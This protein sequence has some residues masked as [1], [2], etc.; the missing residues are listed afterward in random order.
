MLKDISSSHEGRE[1]RSDSP[2]KDGARSHGKVR[3]FATHPVT[4]RYSKSDFFTLRSGERVLRLRGG[5]DDD[6]NYGDLYNTGWYGDSSNTGE[7]GGSGWQED[8]YRYDPFRSEDL[9]K[10]ENPF[11][12]GRNEQAHTSDSYSEAIKLLDEWKIK[13]SYE[14]SEQA[15]KQLEEWR[16]Q[17]HEDSRKDASELLCSYSSQMHNDSDDSN[18]DA[19]KLFNDFRSRMH[20]DS[21]D[22]AINLFNDLRSKMYDVSGE[23]VTGDGHRGVH[24]GDENDSLDEPFYPD[25]SKLENE[26]ARSKFEKMVNAIRDHFKPLDLEGAWRDLQNDPVPHPGRPDEPFQHIKE[27]EESLQ[28]CRNAI[29]TYKDLKDNPKL[30]SGDRLIMEALVSRASKTIDY[31]EKVVYRDQ[32]IP[33]ERSYI[34][35]VWWPK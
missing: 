33:G 19:I 34:F 28:S 10:Y 24:D 20:G 21:K 3:D 35:E 12:Q 4:Y 25:P 15:I 7:Y 1:P 23:N 5:A 26:K 29:E 2:T 30:S 18:E 17:L 14:S 6:A 16:S 9:D 27:V 11:D 8:P 13:T 32:W 22:D 31:V